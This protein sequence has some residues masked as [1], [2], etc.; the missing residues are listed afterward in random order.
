MIT[1]EKSVDV[2]DKKM[3]KKRKFW[4]F[5]G[6]KSDIL[7]D[8]LQ[9]S[10]EDEDKVKLLELVPEPEPND[11][12]LTS[13][14]REDSDYY[15]TDT[16]TD[17]SFSYQHEKT[18]YENTL[19]TTQPF[20]DIEKQHIPDYVSM[21]SY[22]EDDD[23]KQDKGTSISRTD[24]SKPEKHVDFIGVV[25]SADK[26]LPFRRKKKKKNRDKIK[27]LRE[28]SDTDQEEIREVITTKD[29][30]TNVHIP[31]VETE[32]DLEET[33][34]LFI[35]QMKQK[36]SKTTQIHDYKDYEKKSKLPYAT[37]EICVCS[38][39]EE[40]LFN[41]P[42]HLVDSS[43]ITLPKESTSDSDS[44]NKDR[45]PLELRDIPTLS[46]VCTCKKTSKRF[47]QIQYDEIN[48]SPRSNT[49]SINLTSSSLISIL[50]DCYS[51]KYIDRYEKLKRLNRKN[52][53]QKSKFIYVDE[54]GASGR[55]EIAIKQRNKIRQYYTAVKNIPEK[56]KIKS[57]SAPNK[58]RWFFDKLKVC[59]YM[60][61]IVCRKL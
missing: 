29:Q 19:Q 27:M 17:L 52:P 13:N 18:K 49:S 25:K 4:C 5:P 14:A 40:E 31:D 24:L 2:K 28:S 34:P 30:V 57:I 48:E 59:L 46:S 54:I 61:Y 53:K 3:R 33:T 43:L 6:K 37:P 56:V 41:F 42:L 50:P 38:N 26:Q 21:D 39:S 23:Q 7:S 36:E 44:Q 20:K 45:K 16:S 12:E 11:T 35:E 32:D 9:D 8:P 15:S 55:R 51:E 10:T 58:I 47:S 22:R 60:R 1:E